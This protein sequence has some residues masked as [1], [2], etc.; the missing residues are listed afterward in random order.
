MI[1]A[2]QSLR[3]VTNLLFHVLTANYAIVAGKLL[4]NKLGIIILDY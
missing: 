1:S 2:Q 4:T 3:I